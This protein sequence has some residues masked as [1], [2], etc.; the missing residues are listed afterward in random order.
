[1]A[2]E[3]E[4][5]DALRR[6]AAVAAIRQRNFQPVEGLIKLLDDIDKEVRREAHG[7]L[8]TIA[9][10]KDFGPSKNA[11]DAQR[12][13]AIAEW[14]RWWTRK[15][16]LAELMKLRRD[17]ILDEFKSPNPL[18]RWAA[19]TAS[20]RRQLRFG[21]EWIDLLDDDDADVRR[22]AHKAFVDIAEGEDFGPADNAT[23]AERSQAITHWKHWWTKAKLL[24]KAMKLIEA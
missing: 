9:E 13:Q 23:D 8:V 19:V 4:N 15:S 16:F 2:R 24:A 14:T 18:R 5:P 21:D 17:K 6:W 1:M 10:G 22:E 7:T 12:S 3:L 11:T 20:S